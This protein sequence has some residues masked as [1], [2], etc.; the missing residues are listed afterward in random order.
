MHYRFRFFVHSLIRKLDIK[1]SLS[2]RQTT[3]FGTMRIKKGC[4]NNLFRTLLLYEKKGIKPT[5]IL[6]LKAMEVSLY[7]DSRK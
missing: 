1:A 4:G 3:K 5:S 7:A 6:F 2:S